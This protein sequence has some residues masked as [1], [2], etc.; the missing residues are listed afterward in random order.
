MNSHSLLFHIQKYIKETFKIK[1]LY[2]FKE[3]DK[4]LS[5]NSIFLYSK[6]F[7]KVNLNLEN[8]IIFKPEIIFH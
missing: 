6:S 4:N 5:F 1:I 8:N 3:S 2:F 7:I